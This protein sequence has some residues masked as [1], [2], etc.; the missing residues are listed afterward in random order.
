MNS[1]INIGPSYSSPLVR[2]VSPKPAG[3]TIE[4][5]PLAK[6]D[7]VEFTPMSRALPAEVMSK[8]SLRLARAN[9]I[10]AEIDA[11]TYETPERIRGTVERLL[12]II[13]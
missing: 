2:P 9:A 5:F 12:D 4:A 1:I 8:V 10:R 11:G 7:S 13:V 3:G 6:G